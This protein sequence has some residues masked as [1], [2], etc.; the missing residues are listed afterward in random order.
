MCCVFFALLPRRCACLPNRL[1]LVVAVLV[2]A[3]VTPAVPGRADGLTDGAVAV[4]PA[5]AAFLSATLRAREQYD[6]FVKSNAYAALKELPAVRRALDSLEEQ[7]SLPGSPF[8]MAETFMQLPENEQA[9]DVLADMVL[10]IEASGVPVVMH[11]HDEIIA[12]VPADE[13]EAALAIITRQMSTPPA[14]MPELPV[15]CEA[16]IA[17]VY[18]K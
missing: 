6:R 11:V 18:G 7:R 5:D 16:R 3:I 15:A 14:W 9:L 10:R 17:E 4:V 13:A 1:R 8:S 2:L 12:E